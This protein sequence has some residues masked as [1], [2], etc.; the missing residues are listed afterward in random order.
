MDDSRALLRARMSVRRN[1]LGARQ[2]VEAAAG[3]LHSLETLPE[4]M[5]DANVAGYWAVR[6]ELPLNLAVASLKRRDQHYFLP[7]LAEARQLRFAE[8]RDD[9]V[10]QGNRFGIPEPVTPVAE[11]HDAHAMDVVLL[12]LLAFDRSGGRLG[13]GGGWYDTT[14]AFLHDATRPARPLLVGVGYAFQEIESVPVEAWDVPLDYV[15]TE[16]ELIACTPIATP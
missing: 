1:E 14:F 9:A 8:Y 6:G 16:E 13:T 15:A 12:P 3:V 10:L 11:R 7:V 5:T 2:R 4:F